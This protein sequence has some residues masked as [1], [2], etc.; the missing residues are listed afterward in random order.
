VVD[1]FGNFDEFANETGPTDELPMDFDRIVTFAPLAMGLLI[2]GIFVTIV[3][4][5]LAARE[6]RAASVTNY[7]GDHNYGSGMF[8]GRGGAGIA[9]GTGNTLD[10]RRQTTVNIS[11]VA[12]NVRSLRIGVAGLDH[13]DARTRRQINSWIDEADDAARQDDPDPVVVSD[14]LQRAT[15]LIKRSVGLAKAGSEIIEPLKTIAG[16]LGPAGIAL[17]RMLM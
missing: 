17:M 7:Y 14:R 4:S 3:T 1:F 5:L 6:E 9:G 16:A 2:G 13:L 11:V 15:D 8:V 10:N 12:R